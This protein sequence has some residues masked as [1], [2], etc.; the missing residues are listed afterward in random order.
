MTNPDAPTETPPA[1]LPNPPKFALEPFSPEQVNLMWPQLESAIKASLPPTEVTDEAG[2]M[3]GVLVAVMKGDL[4]VWIATKR[5]GESIQLYGGIATTIKN[6]ALG[7][8]IRRLWIYA[9]FL[10]DPPPRDL[11]GVIVDTLRAFAKLNGC[12]SIFAITNNPVIE[13]LVKHL[14][15]TTDYRLVRLEV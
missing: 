9:V 12:K 11:V 5:D 10:H 4:Q 8:G 3:N 1:V 6:D 14:G 13:K 2:A 7:A 15:G